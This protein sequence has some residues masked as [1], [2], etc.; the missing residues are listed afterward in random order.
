MKD[1]HESSVDCCG[2][3]DLAADYCACHVSGLAAESQM[4]VDWMGDQSL[5]CRLRI[6]G[7]RGG[8]S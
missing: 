3:H 7:W 4:I 5:E 2:D 1:S 6:D 8:L